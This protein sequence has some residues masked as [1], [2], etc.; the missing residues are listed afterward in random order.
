MS[1]AVEDECTHAEQDHRP[2]QVGPFAGAERQIAHWLHRRDRIASVVPADRQQRQS[3]D[4]GREQDDSLERPH[5]D[6]GERETLIAP[7]EHREEHHRDA[8]HRQDQGDLEQ[9]PRHDLTF[10]AGHIHN[11]V[12]FADGEQK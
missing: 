2:E 8:H 3:A 9:H 10:R 11:R 12:G 5:A 7:L 4:S 1:R 6:I